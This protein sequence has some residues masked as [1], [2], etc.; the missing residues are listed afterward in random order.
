[1]LPDERADRIL[2]RVDEIMLREENLSAFLDASPW[3]ILVVDKTFKIVYINKTLERISGYRYTEVLGMSM[4]V[5]MPKADGKNH[6]KHEK[7]YLKNPQPREGNHG[8]HPV[9]LTKARRTIDVEISL[10]IAQVREITYYF[11]SI[12]PIASLFNTVR[13]VVL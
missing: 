7:A 3:G 2:E 13:G 5:L 12:R 10:G 4:H 11:A 9:I 1:M 8:N 6:V